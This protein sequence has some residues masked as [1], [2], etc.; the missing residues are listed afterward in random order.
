M[1]QIDFVIFDGPPVLSATVMRSLMIVP[2]CP[3]GRFQ[4]Y[5]C[6]WMSDGLATYR[7][8]IKS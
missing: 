1:M 8:G 6:S 5:F 2:P 3:I 7:V 4:H